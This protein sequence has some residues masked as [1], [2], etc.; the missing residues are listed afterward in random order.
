MSAV[1][2][3]VVVGVVHGLEGL[4]GGGGQED[5][6]GHQLRALVQDLQRLKHKLIK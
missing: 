3:C 5:N 6:E 4:E 1:V 2:C